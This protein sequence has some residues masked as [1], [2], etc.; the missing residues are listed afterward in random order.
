MLAAT[1][2]S[3]KQRSNAAPP[4]RRSPA[5]G[6]FTPSRQPGHCRQSN[7]PCPCRWFKQVV[8]AQ[9]RADIT[10]K[11]EKPKPKYHKACLCRLP[12]PKTCCRTA[13][14]SSATGAGRTCTLA[15]ER[16]SSDVMP[17]AAG[18]GSEQ[19]ASTSCTAVAV[20]AA[21]CM[22]ASMHSNKCQVITGRPKGTTGENCCCLAGAAWQGSNRAR[23][24]HAEH[25]QVSTGNSQAVHSSLLAAVQATAHLR[26]AALLRPCMPASAHLLPA[27]PLL[28]P[29]SA[30]AAAPVWLGLPPCNGAQAHPPGT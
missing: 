23:N 11:G 15:A 25:L 9:Q 24:A 28:A 10:A 19:P 3:F 8:Y 30:P 22:P 14:A 2:N 5:L 17:C 21:C 27:A 26:G 4:N 7:M 1:W 13:S 20:A 18:S 29:R 6:G 12:N 16:S